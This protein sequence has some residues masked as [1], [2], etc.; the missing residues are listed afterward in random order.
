MWILG[1]ERKRDSAIDSAVIYYETAK[2]RGSSM[3]LSD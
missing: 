1:E 3:N 2:I